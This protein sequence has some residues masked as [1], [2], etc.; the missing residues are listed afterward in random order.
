MNLDDTSQAYLLLANEM[1]ANRIPERDLSRIA[2][3]LPPLEEILL[4]ALANRADVLANSQPRLSWTIA[5]VAYSA[6]VAQR[7]SLFVQSLAAWY[8][9]RASNYW[10]QPKKVKRAISQARRGFVK[11][12]EETW[13]A[14][15]D[16]QL[17][18]LAWT[19][20]DL[21]TVVETLRQAL[22]RLEYAGFN[23]F[24]PDCRLAL[25]YA[26]ILVKKYDEAK[27][28]I[29][30]SEV[31]FID[32]G[33]KLNQARCWLHEASYLRR[34]DHYE[35]AL[36]KLEQARKVFEVVNAS[37]DRAKAYYQ[38]GLCH[39]LRTDNLSAAAE[40]FRR[41]IDLF[42]TCDMDLWRAMCVTN[43]GSVYLFT[44]ELAQADQYYDAARKVFV[45]HGVAGLWADNLQDCAEVNILRGRP[46]VSIEQFKQA[47]SLH[48][49][50]GLPLPAA[51]SITNLGKAYSQSGRYQDA[52]FYLEQAMERLKSLESPLRLG[53]CEKYTALI[54][55]QLGQPKIAHEYLDQ[56]TSNYESADQHALLPEMY[57]YRAGAYFQQGL[58]AN[59]VEWLKKSL[60]LANSYKMRPQANLAR[61]LLGEA[62][63]RLGRYEESIENLKYAQEESASMG[64]LMDQA[65]GF[66]ASGEYYA[67]ISSPKQAR[68]AFA[69]KVGSPDETLF[70][71]EQGKASTLLRQLQ[72]HN[73]PARDAVSQEVNDLQAEL[74]LLQVR[75]RNLRRNRFPSRPPLNSSN[76]AVR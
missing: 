25:A 64:M 34:E 76:C 13:I 18:A 41:A 63:L 31:A 12:K 55:L 70:L 10:G 30:L 7:R 60:A 39:L 24:V 16:W 6:A 62:L 17:N 74:G 65:S 2:T 32:Q 23:D 71:V 37:V 48:E 72:V 73:V 69:S 4:S 35:Q 42:S 43:L 20:P 61:R 52:L 45:R 27:K 68:Q 66:I 36:D 29:L 33:D 47:A 57:S 14:A 40:Q 49:S 56:A 54:W 53:T 15:C 9:G 26:Q 8:L 22:E 75:L 59:G 58:D 51:I 44:G 11:L 5:R 21:P 67:L 46:A 50:L 28:N 38:A 1:L 19:K 3:R